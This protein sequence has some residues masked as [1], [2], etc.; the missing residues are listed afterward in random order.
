[1]VAR[2]GMF[3]DRGRKGRG[4]IRLFALLIVICGWYLTP[5]GEA[6]PH[7][8]EEIR[9]GL[10]VNQKTIELVLPEAG[11]IISDQGKHL[12]LEAG[13][14][15]LRWE[16]GGI[17]LGKLRLA[18]NRLHVLSRNAG[19]FLGYRNRLYRGSFQ[20]LRT[21]AGLTLVNLLGLEEYLLGVVP[22]EMPAGWAPEALKTQAVAARTYTIGRMGVHSAEGFDLCAGTHCQVYGGASAEH[23]TTNRA[24]AE[25][26][27]EVMLFDNKPITAVYHSASGGYTEDS[28]NV[29]GWISPYLQGVPDQDRSPY[30]SWEKEISW[31]EFI[32]KILRK[33]PELKYV[34]AVEPTAYG[35]SGRISRLRLDGGAVTLEITGEQFR[36]LFGLRSTLFALIFEGEAGRLLYRPGETL[37]RFLPWQEEEPAFGVDPAFPE[38]GL[39]RLKPENFRVE[40]VRIVGSGW[41]H[42]VG[43]S[44]WGS[45]AQAE[46]GKTYRDILGYYYKEIR[47]QSMYV[48]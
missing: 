35:V 43:L 42:G 25:T 28:A 38:E 24:V 29:W 9:I 8:P 18:A 6:E 27:G 19:S 11:E 47:I 21:K 37:P 32:G 17:Y 12:V 40:R 22:W 26:R 45:K 3:L 15:R 1:L 33:Y 30:V 44:Q 16:S 48:L 14:H 13:C 20:V 39:F 46:E 2:S 4:M 34:R 7:F 5:V 36:H 41:G 10:G 23:E 31:S